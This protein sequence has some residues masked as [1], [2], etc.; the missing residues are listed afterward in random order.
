MATEFP[1]LAVDPE[2]IAT[3]PD[4]APLAVELPIAM[5]SG[6]DAVAL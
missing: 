2:P 4:I 5:P 3:G 1:A 6:A